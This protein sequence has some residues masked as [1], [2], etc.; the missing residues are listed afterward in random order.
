MAHEIGLGRN[1]SE[2]PEEPSAAQ[3]YCCYPAELKMAVTNGMS[4]AGNKFEGFKCNAT[5]AIEFK[6]V[7]HEPDIFDDSKVFHPDMTHQLESI[8]GYKDLKVQIYCSAARMITYVNV[9]Y[10]AKIDPE[11]YDGV[12]ADDILGLLSKH[13]Q[14][15]FLTNRDAFISQ[16]TKDKTFKPFGELVHSY[17]TTREDKQ[18]EFEV[19]KTDIEAIG[20][21][22]F[23]ER[24]QPFLLFF[25][26]AAS[27][28]D[29][30][31]DRWD[32]YLLF[33]KYR[34][35]GTTI[36]AFAGYMTVY[37]YYAYPEK[38][39]PRISQVLVMP[40]FQRQ[41]HGATLIQTFYNSCY[42]RHDIL[43]ITVEDPSENFQR[44]RDF[45]DCKNCMRLPSFQP[46]ELHQGFSEKM[47]LETREKL[48]INRKQARRIYEI[49]RL[50]ATNMANKEQQRG[51]RLDIKKRLN[52]PFQK[53]GR[54]FQKL[55]RALEPTE[56]AA[57]LNNLSVEQR[58]EYLEKHYEEVITE[59]R[60]VIERLATNVD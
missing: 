13:L 8:F 28:I 37:N 29:V 35:A 49:L 18:L 14:P 4:I 59:Y 54:D 60:A 38:I 20:F 5:D 51:Y 1:V 7:R 33:E 24:I 3:S 27:Y 53:N 9:A 43:D 25:V 34:E 48:F 23:H 55:K 12:K 22:D 42:N 56:L 39:R 46:E 58:M 40:P 57:T 36:Y 6:L 45:V 19:Y 52:S 31:D 26:D 41:G 17:T 15:G 2:T 44:V 16:L 50:R 30:D 21:R 47:R 10:S 11:Q 32:Y